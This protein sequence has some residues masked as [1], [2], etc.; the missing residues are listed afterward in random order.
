MLH[1]REQRVEGHLDRL[2]V[3]PVVALTPGPLAA[4]ALSDAA[5]QCRNRSEPA[6]GTE[7]GAGRLW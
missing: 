4:L 6:A 5:I 3:A 2:G 7:E 1:R